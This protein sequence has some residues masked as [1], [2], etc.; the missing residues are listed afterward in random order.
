MSPAFAVNNE[1]ADGEEGPCTLTVR[2]G[3]R[4]LTVECGAE[5]SVG[6]ALAAAGIELGDGDVLNYLPEDR[7]WDGMELE[8]T[9]YPM[10]QSPEG[11]APVS[12][13]ADALPGDAPAAL[14]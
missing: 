9:L 3:S 6:E 14:T 8:L 5:T 4:V 12:G 11:S 10:A 2:A 7:V 13:L 1:F